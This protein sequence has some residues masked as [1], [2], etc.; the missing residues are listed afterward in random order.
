MLCALC[1]RAAA[2]IGCDRCRAVAFCGVCAPLGMPTH[3]AMCVP[4]PVEGAAARRVDGSRE[5]LV[6]VRLPQDMH[7]PGV[8]PALKDTAAGPGGGG[9]VQAS[10]VVLSNPNPSP[11]AVYVIDG[12]T[13]R[14]VASAVA[15][16]SSRKPAEVTAGVEK[17]ARIVA[18]VKKACGG[19]EVSPRQTA[20]AAAL[21]AAG[22]VPPLVACLGE[23]RSD[24][25]RGAAA[26]I[27][28][29][30][31]PVGEAH[32]AAVRA[33]GAAPQLAALLRSPSAP[34]AGAA[35]RVVCDLARDK[36]A[37]FELVTAGV[38]PGLIPLLA[39]TGA[40]VPVAAAS[41]L[42]KLCHA[43]DA[44]V[45]AVVAAGGV[46]AL[47]GMLDNASQLAQRVAA[48]A[49]CHL[50]QLEDSRGEAAAA[51]IAAAGGVRRL[52]QLTA[53]PSRGVQDIAVCTLRKI[54]RFE[55][56]AAA[57]A[58]AGAIPA[59]LRVL[60]SGTHIV[61]TL[62]AAAG[63]LGH[64]VLSDDS[65]AG[66]SIV[67]A[68]GVRV[69]IHLLE[70]PWEMLIAETAT[71]V[72]WRLFVHA[73]AV[74]EALGAGVTERLI[75]LLASDSFEKQMNAA[76]ALR[77][78][79]AEPAAAAA[80][81]AAAGGIA[82]LIAVLASPPAEAA[83]RAHVEYVRMS[84][85]WTLYHVSAA[86]VAAEA[87]VAGGA[88]APLLS[89]AAAA[90]SDEARAGAAHALVSL[91]LVDGGGGVATARAAVAAAGM[92]PLV[93]VLGSVSGAQRARA[94]RALAALA[95]DADAREALRG[96]AGARDA[97]AAV[98]T[99]DA[100]VA[101]AVAAA[102]RALE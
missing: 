1:N 42:S 76:I 55:S 31:T 68:G 69:L 93:A 96:A 83:P 58:A 61:T 53:S 92:P 12:A 91:A 81:A 65:A 51:T 86:D 14:K 40:D 59:L 5:E 18:D 89:L 46:P 17:L 27:L 15:R 57:M 72:L 50:A 49:L 22:G 78:F 45:V 71:F 32:R 100:V 79:A 74:T 90:T 47:L 4:M 3:L 99:E 102:W 101:E 85:A 41:A 6:F 73:A 44:H 80:V 16:L 19:A 34:A 10:A 25:I 13:A 30:I 21:V 82:A 63:A 39:A 62:D 11:A 87:S 8:T 33:A 48:I 75:T 84:A 7:R 52:L 54:S 64:I 9:A 60:R 38:I 67:A 97:L 43:H 29:L 20:L 37:A 26:V 2:R 23:G 77:A 98:T 36:V 94:A 88:I 56:Q 35:A 28:R 24:R 70:P 95:A 66:A